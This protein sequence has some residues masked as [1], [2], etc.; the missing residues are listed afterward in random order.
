MEG[1][2]KGAVLSVDPSEARIHAYDVLNYQYHDLK[3]FAP[4]DRT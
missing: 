1:E 4:G 2:K 3:G